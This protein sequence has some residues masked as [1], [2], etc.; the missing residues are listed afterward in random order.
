[1]TKEQFAEVEALPEGAQKV[2]KR[3][4]GFQMELMVHGAVVGHPFEFVFEDSDVLPLLT[5]Y[6]VVKEEGVVVTQVGADVMN[7]EGVL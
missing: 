3:V 2:L 1:M 4:L 6:F 7:E 5:K